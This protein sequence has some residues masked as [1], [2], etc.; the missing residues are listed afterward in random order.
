MF[1][2][3]TTSIEICSFLKVLKTSCKRMYLS[4]LVIDWNICNNFIWYISF[5]LINPTLSLRFWYPQ[6][7]SRPFSVYVSN[8]KRLKLAHVKIPPHT[9]PLP[10]NWF[11]I[12]KPSFFMNLALTQLTKISFKIRLSKTKIIVLRQLGII[13]FWI[14][15]TCQ[16]ERLL[17]NLFWKKQQE[18]IFVLLYLSR[19]NE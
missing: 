14:W 9:L 4:T 2:T 13:L 8:T 6:N 15:L 17:W 1:S 16:T 7:L 19:V 3:S 5:T 12:W 11:Y 10:G 18:C